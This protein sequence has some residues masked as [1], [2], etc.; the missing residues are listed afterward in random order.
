MCKPSANLNPAVDQWIG[1]RHEQAWHE[2]CRCD[3]VIDGRTDVLVLID[4]QGQTL[5]LRAV[6]WT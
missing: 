5:F 3:E 6:L 2:K 4:M 1:S